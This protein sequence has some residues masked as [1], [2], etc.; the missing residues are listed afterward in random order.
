MKLENLL[1]EKKTK[2]LQRWF[3]LILETYPKD[4]QPFLKNRTDRFANPVGTTISEGIERLFD[5]LL[6]DDEIDREIVLPILESIIRI[7]ATQDL[8]PS[9]AIA[10]VFFLKQ[11]LHELFKKEMD[12]KHVLKDILRF[13]SRV[14]GLVLMAFDLYMKYRERLYEISANHAKNQVSGLLR[15]AGLA[16]E[17]P[18]WQPV[19]EKGT[20][21]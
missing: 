5:E 7:R 15:Q 19:S 17:V 13:E 4:T 11:S 20:N 8:T 18:E 21:V 6:K 2:I 9:Q 1:S 3:N 16:C 12:D 10:F 14:D